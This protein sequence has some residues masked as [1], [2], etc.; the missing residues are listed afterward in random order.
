[1]R[2]LNNKRFR[3]RFVC[4]GLTK[5]TAVKTTAGTFPRTLNYCPSR[6]VFKTSA[7]N[8]DPQNVCTAGNYTGTVRLG[9]KTFFFFF[10][11]FVSLRTVKRFCKHRVHTGCTHTT[12]NDG[13]LDEKKININILTILMVNNGWGKKKKES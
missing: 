4:V 6:F 11:P 10:V 9:S 5:R 13:R 3:N 7:T 2:L 1:M 12:T 8:V